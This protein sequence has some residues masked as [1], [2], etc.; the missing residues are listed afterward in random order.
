M[1]ATNGVTA[2][3]LPNEMLPGC[4]QGC[5]IPGIMRQSFF[6]FGRGYAV[7]VRGYAGLCEKKQSKIEQNCCC[8]HSCQTTDRQFCLK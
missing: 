3:S 7:I 2:R 4:D 5:I 8:L 1:S 6:P